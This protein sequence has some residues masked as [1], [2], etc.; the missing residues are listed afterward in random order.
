MDNKL[1]KAFGV[2]TR[3]NITKTIVATDLVA[4]LK[5][6][7]KDGFVGIE[8]AETPSPMNKLDGF[9]WLKTQAI[10]AD[11]SAKEAI[12]TKLNELT[13][14]AKSGEVKVQAKAP[15][16]VAQTTDKVTA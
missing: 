10:Y 16:A 9:N 11:A 14:L 8:L 15:K 13:K 3:N 2:A 7:S 1:Y 6:Y 4:R 5:Q 12:D